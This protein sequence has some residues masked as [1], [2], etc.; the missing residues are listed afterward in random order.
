MTRRSSCIS[1]NQWQNIYSINF[2]FR[3]RCPCYGG[4]SWQNID[5]TGKFIAYDTFGDNPRPSHYAGNALSSFPACPLSFAQTTCSSC[6][7]AEIQP[8]PVITG[9]D[10]KSVLIQT[11]P[12][13]SLHY[14]TN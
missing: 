8:W 5:C 1:Q 2:I 13:K 10:N 7:I 14:F 3:K 12:F 9:E 6:M 4:Q 11:I